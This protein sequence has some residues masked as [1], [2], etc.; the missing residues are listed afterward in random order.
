RMRPEQLSRRNGGLVETATARSD[1]AGKRIRYRRQQGIAHR[2]VLRIQL[3]KIEAARQSVHTVISHISY[4]NHVV[5]CGRVLEAIHPL[6][7]I[8]CLAL[9]IDRAGTEPYVRHSTQ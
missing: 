4:V 3:V 6:L 5:R 9:R 8:V 1:R 7:V 2:E